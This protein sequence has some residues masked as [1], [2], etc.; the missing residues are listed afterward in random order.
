[1]D[2]EQA[3]NLV[4]LY[5]GHYPEEFIELYLEYYQMTLQEFTEVIDSW[6]NEDLFEK[7]DGHWK[8]KFTVK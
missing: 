3:V 5:D 6:A 7:I 8:P 4:N 1:M 2:R